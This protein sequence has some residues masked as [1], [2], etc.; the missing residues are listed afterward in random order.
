MQAAIDSLSPSDKERLQTYIAESQMR[1]S[2]S[3]YNKVVNRCFMDCVNSFRHKSLDGKED[4]CVNNCTRKF[5][6]FTQR[7]A[8]RFA[9]AQHEFASSQ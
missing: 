3:V 8:V 4:E 2:M 5:L 6:A 1:D 9:E 7:A